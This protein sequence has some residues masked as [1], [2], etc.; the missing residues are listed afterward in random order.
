MK[1]ATSREELPRKVQKYLD[2]LEREVE[3]PLDIISI[4]AGRDETLVADRQ[5]A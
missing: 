2:A 1:G 4:G 3:C 5:Y